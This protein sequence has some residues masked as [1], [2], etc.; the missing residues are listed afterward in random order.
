MESGLRKGLRA[1][2]TALGVLA[3]APVA[4]GQTRERGPQAIVSSPE[5][6]VKQKELSQEEIGIVEKNIGV[7]FEELRKEYLVEVPINLGVGAN[8]V[9]HIGQTHYS[10]ITEDATI[11]NYEIII[12]SQKMQLRL[13]EKMHSHRAIKCV[14]AEGE[15][16]EKFAGSSDDLT[17][18][19]SIFDT[20]L[21]EIRKVLLNYRQDR[22][23][24]L[25]KDLGKR[26]VE[27]SKLFDGDF[28][29]GPFHSHGGAWQKF[30]E[31]TRNDPLI[32]RQPFFD[33]ADR[34]FRAHVKKRGLPQP[35]VLGGYREFARQYGVQVICPTQKS[36]FSPVRS[37]SDKD[38]VYIIRER[39]AIS[40][41]PKEENSILVYGYGHNFSRALGESNAGRN[42]EGK[43]QLGLIK[44]TPLVGLKPIK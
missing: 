16:D 2:G 19:G 1:I 36:I 18:K 5:Q 31:E 30:L 3:G 20:K 25:L 34:E 12:G 44:I 14:Y 26:I 4:S 35:I 9:T 6:G 11:R 7:S 22:N 21:A 27:H 42:R 24:E 38:T 39:E 8:Y 33:S 13:L 23:P 15:A 29:F 28:G 40:Y 32:N 10:G 37:L 17:S 43:S 41:L